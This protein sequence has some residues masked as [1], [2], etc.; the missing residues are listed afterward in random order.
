[1]PASSARLVPVPNREACGVG[2]ISL[3]HW[4]CGLLRGHGWGTVPVAPTGF[5]LDTGE[6]I[7][8]RIHAKKETSAPSAWIWLEQRDCGRGGASRARVQVDRGAGLTRPCRGDGA[9]CVGA[10]AQASCRVPRGMPRRAQRAT[11]RWR[12]LPR[13]RQACAD[14]VERSR[15]R[16]TASGT[17]EHDAK[18]PPHSPRAFEIGSG[19][20]SF[21]TSL[22][23]W[24][25][26]ATVS[27][28]V[29]P[30]QPLAKTNV[31]DC[32]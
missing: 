8:C 24:R 27:R 25:G 6:R 23:T 17:E 9:R 4:D 31:R 14:R 12:R 21:V 19:V 32:C 1:M 3:A 15:R 11:A 13:R 2:R 10:K 16:P 22:R 28:P 20:S 30:S 18:S 5:R 26:W 29:R 7:T